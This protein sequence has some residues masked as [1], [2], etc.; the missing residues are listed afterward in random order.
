MKL[1]WERLKSLLSSCNLNVKQLIIV[2]FTPT[3]RTPLLAHTR[4]ERIKMNLER[5]KS[6]NIQKS[7]S[8]SRAQLGMPEN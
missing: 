6:R 1:L 7:V 3:F 8:L 5:V 4:I 2:D